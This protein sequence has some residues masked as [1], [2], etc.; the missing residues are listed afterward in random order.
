VARARTSATSSRLPADGPELV[1]VGRVGRPHGVDGAFVVEGASDD[2]RRFELGAALLV[3]GERA[4]VVLSRRVGGGR[5][6]IKLD[7]AVERG[8]E[9]AV[10][11][12]DLPP[13]DEDSYYVADLVGLEVVEEGGRR[14]GA[15]VDVLPGVA[16]D[17]LELDS[18]VLLPLVEDCVREVQLPQ[19]RVVVAPGFADHR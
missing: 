13:P 11:R 2:P 12:E 5:P 9:L 10:R 15:V 6:A 17:V 18:G 4:T 8:A 14:L 16:N 1:R 3:G 19:R 7:R